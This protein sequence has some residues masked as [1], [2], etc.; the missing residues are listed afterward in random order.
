MMMMVVVVVVMMMHRHHGDDDD[1]DD[2]CGSGDDGNDGYSLPVMRMIS[3]GG[4]YF[5]S[6]P[7]SSSRYFHPADIEDITIHKEEEG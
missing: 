3:G 2:D 7:D 5:P 4:Y 6:C 1:D